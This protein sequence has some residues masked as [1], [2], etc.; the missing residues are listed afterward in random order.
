MKKILIFLVAAISLVSCSQYDDVALWNK[1]MN[2]NSRLLTLEELCEQMN[3]NITS[4]QTVVNA[5][6]ENDYITS[7]NPVYNGNEIIGYTIS[8]FKSEPITI[9]HGSKGE[10]GEDGYTPVIGVKLDADGI[11]YW[12]LD[13]TW[14]LD[15]VGNK[16]RAEGRDGQ[17]GTDGKDGENGQD[18][19][20]GKDGI[21]PKFKIEN[22]DWY[23]STDNGQ[24]WENIGRATG[25]NGKDGFVGDSMFSNIDTSNSEYVI[26]TLVD[27]T[28]IKIP[29]WHAFEEL[30]KLC[31][32]MNTNIMSLQ[33]IVEALQEND[34]ITGVTPLLENGAQIGYTITFKKSGP[35]VIYH[36]NDGKDGMDGKD[37][38][39]PKIGVSK[40][41]DG[42][43]Y[44]TLDGE[45]LLD[46][47]DNKIKAEGKDG[48]D[49]NGGSSSGDAGSGKDGEDGITPELKIEDGY[50]FVSYDNGETWRKLGK[51]TGENG[52]DGQPGENGDS[53]FKNVDASN[54]EYIIFTL[55]DG[56]EIKIPTWYAFEELKKFCNELNTNIQ[57]LQTIIEAME[58]GDY[59]VSCMPLIENGKQIG[60]TITFAKGGPIVIYHGKDGKDG[61]NSNDGDNDSSND[62][63]PQIGVK[64]DVD[65]NLYWTFDGEWLT[66]E[67]GA[68]I[69]VTGKDGQTGPKG[70]DGIT[71]QLKIEDGY[72]Y[73]SYDDGQKWQKLGKATGEDGKDGEQGES[74]D[75]IFKSINTS[76]PDYV[77]ITLEDGTEIK[78]SYYSLLDIT[79]DADKVVDGVVGMESSSTLEVGYVITG[80]TDNISIDVV[81]SG[82]VKAIVASRTATEGNIIITTGASIDEFTRVVVLVSNGARTIMRSLTFE[83][84]SSSSGQDFVETAGGINL[85]MIFVEGGTF[86]MGATEE[87]GSDADENEKPVHNVTVSSYYIGKFEVTHSLWKTVTGWM[88]S[89]V[90]YVENEPIYF[91]S[92]NDIQIFITELR[93]KTGKNYRLPTEAEWEYAARGGNKSNGYKYSGSNN[94]DD[95]AWYHASLRPVGSKLPNELGI[96]DMSGNVAEVCSDWYGN[97]SSEDTTNPT[98]PSSGSEHVVRGGHWNASYGTWCRVSY[99]YNWNGSKGNCYGLRVVLEP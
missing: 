61:Q 54:S 32:E 52:K 44:W 30:M 87:Q 41:A 40:D 37:G 67:S 3:T 4:L 21:T 94:V 10:K 47:K 28:V 68:K 13:D 55:V 8:F 83:P 77:I 69:P 14:L 56:T 35:I 98:G 71:P 18:G 22:G 39:S 46:D 74:G 72:W 20:N 50:W 92:W 90:D 62:N 95:V 66:D 36:G 58:A 81:A 73:V 26:F 12:T 16:I 88:P 42:I 31:N 1:T 96:Y 57:S 27:G 64:R 78:L 43:Y 80:N 76:N 53:F 15:E 75:S 33:K 91:V 17:N 34:Y 93:A 23:V 24:T 45:W 49:G 82:E 5:L 63:A 29:T 59:I 86:K 65:G 48:K 2:I 9:Y 19:A 25:E 89:Y 60:Y 85:P 70:E 6:Q 51:A 84:S 38:Y 7:V 79:F 99:R 97:Y 11:Y